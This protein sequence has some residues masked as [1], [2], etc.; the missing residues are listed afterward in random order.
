MPERLVV[1][2]APFPEPGRV[3]TRL[4]QDGVSPETAIPL[5]EAFL[6]DIL[7]LARHSALRA[8]CWLAYPG[9]ASNLPAMTTGVWRIPQHGNAE[10]ERL[11]HIFKEGF[12][13]GFR[14]ICV[15]G[16]DMPHL[17]VAFLQ[18]AFGRLAY[19]VDAVFGPTEAGGCY[20]AGL[21]EL[22]PEL[23]SD[24]PWGTDGVLQHLLI[25]AEKRGRTVALLPA[26][27]NLNTLK[28]VQRLK[29][30]LTRG[31]AYA[32]VTASALAEK[33]L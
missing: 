29:R 8:D 2:A 6:D 20:L 13:A 27:Y 14:S 28:D 1:I 25:S 23:F 18:E 24:I 9:E 5:A 31:V 30:D 19:G 22:H 21:R 11:V 15:I 4:I 12:A 7:T 33:M 16:A 10:G 3:E 26:G 17:P 32:P